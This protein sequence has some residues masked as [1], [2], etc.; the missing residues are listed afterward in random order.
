MTVRNVQLAFKD[1]RARRSPVTE[2]VRGKPA[3]AKATLICGRSTSVSGRRVAQ[4]WGLVP[5]CSASAA[6]RR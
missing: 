6:S 4:S 3:K 2:A 1:P 5:G